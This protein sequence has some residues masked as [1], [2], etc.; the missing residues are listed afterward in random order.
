MSLP[1]DLKYTKEHEW[2]KVDGETA[3]IGITE[4]A[5]SELGDIIFIEFPNIDQEIDKNEPF[6]TIEAVKTVAD[7]FAPVSGKVIKINETLEDNP[8]FVNS[9]PYVNGWIVKVSISDTSELEE[10]MS[11][12]KYEG[13]IR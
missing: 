7:L 1:E 13:L 6:G 4:Y 5:Q 12:D 3:I 9:D 8:E 2:L 10:L 11:A